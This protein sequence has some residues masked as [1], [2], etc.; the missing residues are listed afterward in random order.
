MR[1]SFVLKSLQRRAP[2]LT[3][4]PETFGL[5]SFFFFFFLT[6]LLDAFV[7]V[8]GVLGLTEESPRSLD[9]KKQTKPAGNERE[10]KSLHKT[11]D[12]ISMV[13]LMRQR[14]FGGSL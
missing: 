14:V 6:P 12:A 11:D 10:I 9:S 5:F 3:F 2:R 1:G 8:Y 13:M 4:T 7:M